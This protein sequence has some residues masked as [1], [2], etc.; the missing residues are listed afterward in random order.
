MENIC[1]AVKECNKST[2]HEKKTKPKKFTGSCWVIFFC[3]EGIYNFTNIVH[4]R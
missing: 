2:T 1:A 4:Q 3:S